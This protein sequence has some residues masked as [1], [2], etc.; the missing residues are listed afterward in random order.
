MLV[1]VTNKHGEPLMPCYPR[2]ARLLLKQQQA[3]VVKQTPFTI[4]LLHGSTGYKQE[5]SLG[6]DQGTKHVGLSAT[7]EKVVLFEGEVK[8]RTDI[9][10]NLATRSE[11]RKSRRNRK[12]RYRKARFLNR[13]KPEG[14]LAP[15][16]QHKVDSTIRILEKLHEILPI[17]HISMEVAQFDIQKIKNPSI[18]GV[19]Y[20][21]GEQL[22]FWNVREYVFYRDNH[23]CQHCKGKSKDSILNVHH[24]ESRKTGGDSP[25]NLIT[26]CE[27]CHHKIHSEG[28]EYLFQRKR[29][30]LRDATQMT[31]MRWF[32]Y[33]K[34]KSLYPHLQLTY[35]YITKNTRIS[36]G[37]E[38]SHMI[39]ARC[40]SGN[41]LS[42]PSTDSYL[43]KQVRKNNRQLHKAKILKG[44]V[45]KNNQAPKFVNGFQLFDKVIFNDQICF[46]FGRRSS[47]YFDLRLLDGSI[48]HRSANSKNLIL[49][50]KASTWLIQSVSSSNSSPT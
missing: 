26:L 23:T 39:D 42:R 1:F 16:V 41:P 17:K 25:D 21:Q 19:E 18:Q 46:I 31:I 29:K 9:Q 27:T 47:G 34:A 37:L 35:G 44:G 7:T 10:K 11:L 50:E 49:L 33:N 6:V 20:Q 5:V 45:R 30:S 8:L 22:G 43:I 24:I 36:N 4:Q 32:I 38:K 12:T 13:K 14:W 3:K 28:L 2:K 40:I 15:S 48:I